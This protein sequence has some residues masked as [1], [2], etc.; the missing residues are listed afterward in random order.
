MN[1]YSDELY[2]KPNKNNSIVYN[3]CIQNILSKSR[4]I[5]WITML[6][7]NTFILLN[8]A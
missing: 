5:N 7:V 2:T 4:E 3:D 8:Y 6:L 1:S